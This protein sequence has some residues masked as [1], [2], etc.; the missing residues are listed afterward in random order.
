[1][2]SIEQSRKHFQ[3]NRRLNIHLFIQIHAFIFFFHVCI[4]SFIPWV[5]QHLSWVTETGGFLWS[6]LRGKRQPGKTCSPPPSVPSAC[7]GKPCTSSNLS[8]TVSLQHGKSKSKQPVRLYVVFHVQS[9]RLVR[10]QVIQWSFS[11]RGPPIPSNQT[12]I[13][14]FQ[15]KEEKKRTTT[16]SK[17]VQIKQMYNKQIYEI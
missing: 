7:G 3:L 1:M 6:T 16:N 12:K 14:H 11:P 15:K 9:H 10:L 17:Y 2:Y 8:C 4:L 5:F 13:T